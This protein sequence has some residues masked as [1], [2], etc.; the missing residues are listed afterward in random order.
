[1]VTT[2]PAGPAIQVSVNATSIPR[3]GTILAT[4]ST[5]PSVAQVTFTLRNS[6][7][8]A[9]QPVIQILDQGMVTLS[10]DTTPYAPGDYTIIAAVPDTTSEASASF[11][12]T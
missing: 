11:V 1:V 2:L 6:T 4:V 3:G 8:F 12:I 10:L 5:D 9:S 7:T